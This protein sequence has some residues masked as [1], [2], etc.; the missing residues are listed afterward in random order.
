MDTPSDEEILS[1]VKDFLKHETTSGDAKLQLL[2]FLKDQPSY[3]ALHAA[4]IIPT[5]DLALRLEAIEHIRQYC[6]RL[7]DRD[8]FYFTTVQ[9]SSFLLMPLELLSTLQQ[10]APAYFLPSM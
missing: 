3:L 5:E 10:N 2:K 1:D 4:P 8:I 7:L 9:L 6:E